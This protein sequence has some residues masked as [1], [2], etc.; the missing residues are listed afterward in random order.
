MVN[1]NPFKKIKTGASDSAE[2]KESVEKE[3]AVHFNAR[4]FLIK[5]PWISE[6]ATSMSKINKYV[7]VVDGKAN[8]PMVK[9]A[10][11]NIYGVN[12]EDVNITLA[13]AKKKR[14][15]RTVGVKPG[16]KKAVV[17]LAQGQSIDILPR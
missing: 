4:P 3:Q 9:K 13:K 17:T 8:K 2:K 12:V 11:E 14:L 1:L 5:K 6:K 16:Y 7:F 15:G 10:I